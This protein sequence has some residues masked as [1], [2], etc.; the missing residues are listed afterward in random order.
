MDVLENPRQYFTGLPRAMFP[1]SIEA[2]LRL[3]RLRAGAGCWSESR[4]RG[5]RSGTTAAIAAFRK[6]SVF[7]IGRGKLGLRLGDVKFR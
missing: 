5:N 2:E 1:Q 3:I 4:P 6:E 7:F